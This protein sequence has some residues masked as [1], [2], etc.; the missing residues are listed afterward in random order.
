M[1][2]P[3]RFGPAV[4][5]GDELGTLSPEIASQVGLPQCSVISLPYD[6]MTA[7]L[8]AGLCETGNALD[9]SGTV[10][11]FG[12]LHPAQVIDR[13][14]RIHSFPLPANSKW[15][16]R[17][18]TSAS[19]S[20]LEWAKRE[21]V[22]DGFGAFDEL[23]AASPPGANGIMFLPYLAGARSVAD[24]P[25]GGTIGIGAHQGMPVRAGNQGFGIGRATAARNQEVEVPFGSSAGN[26]EEKQTLARQNPR[27]ET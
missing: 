21:F 10:T 1:L 14:R 8:E 26:R 12:V 3:P 22:G 2:R 16:V 19:G 17:G 23:V 4:A 7:Y 24:V 27:E 13:E 18:V 9:V 6:S 20:A 5:S 15:L 25:P 11:S